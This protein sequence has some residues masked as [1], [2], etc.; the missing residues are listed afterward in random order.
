MDTDTDLES[1]SSRELHDRAV[2]RALHHADLGFFWEL[3]R[4]IPAA[5]TLQGQVREAGEDL[6]KVSALLSDALTSGEGDLADALR[7]LYL[8]YLTK[9]RPK[10]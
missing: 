2:R 5:E 10:T 7:P 8:D 3:L 4:A 6:T 1:L 9:H